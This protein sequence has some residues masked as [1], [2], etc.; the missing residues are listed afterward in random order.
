MVVAR[1][2]MLGT[3]WID[4]S[5]CFASAEGDSRTRV[6]GRLTTV[7]QRLVGLGETR[8]QLK[9]L[10]YNTVTMVTVTLQTYC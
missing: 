6:L 9:Q 7:F 2:G 8:D 3:M 4:F 1:G 10:R 5:L